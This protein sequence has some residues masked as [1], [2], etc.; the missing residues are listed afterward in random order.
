MTELHG[1]IL[2]D[3][4]FQDFTSDDYIAL[5]ADHEW[6][7]RQGKKVASPI[8]AA[9]CRQKYFF[10]ETDYGHRQK[11][12]YQACVMAFINKNGKHH[13]EPKQKNWPTVTF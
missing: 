5:L 3:N 1:R 8:S 6:E 10:V 13:S 12:V 2:S 9:R 11:H 4:R 7:N